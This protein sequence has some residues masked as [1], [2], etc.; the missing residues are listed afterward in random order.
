[1]PNLVSTDKSITASASFCNI[2][3]FI[4]DNLESIC[5]SNAAKERTQL[6]YIKETNIFLGWL[7]SNYFTIDS[8]N[9]YRKHLENNISVANVTKNISLAALRNVCKE[10]HFR[11]V[12]SKDLSIKLPYFKIASGHK[13]DGF[14][15]ADLDVMQEHINSIE[16]E[17]QRARI[18]A[19]FTILTIQGF[20][21]FEMLNLEVTDYVRYEKKLRIQGKGKTEKETVTCFDKTMKV[22]DTYLAV[23]GKR[24]GYIFT[25]E[26]G[27]TKGEKL[28]ERGLRKIFEKVFDDLKLREKQEGDKRYNKST[29]GF[30]HFFV[31]Y[32]LKKTN[33]NITKTMHYSRHKS[34]TALVMYNDSIDKAEND[35]EINSI[36]NF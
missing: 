35:K 29:H 11:D 33:G 12:V 10:L 22:L 16:N 7:G 18:N 27:T 17:V 6:K 23:S 1:M 4:R 3:Q 13:K 25:S 9:A 20:R 36:M 30:R 34:T 14:D 2:A 8:I 28:S 26:G 19:M 5:R 15:K 31:T 24:S 32:L 21:Q